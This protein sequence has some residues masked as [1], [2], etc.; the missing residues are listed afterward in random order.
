LDKVHLAGRVDDT[1]YSKHGEHRHERHEFADYGD[2]LH[3][4]YGAGFDFACQQKLPNRIKSS[5]TL[6]LCRN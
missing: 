6:R 4:T 5:L 3:R 2:V 1:A